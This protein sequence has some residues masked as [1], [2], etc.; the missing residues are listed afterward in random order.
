MQYSY[1]PHFLEG[2]SK[3]NNPLEQF[4][5]TIVF[6][7]T[8][9]HCCLIQEKPFNPILGETYQGVINGN[10]IYMEQTSHHPPAYSSLMKTDNYQVSSSQ[11]IRVVLNTNS[12]IC[13]NVGRTKVVYKNKNEVI[14]EKP[15]LVIRG[16]NVGNRRI[17]LEK[18]MYVYSPKH[19]LA[20][21]LSFGPKKGG[22]FSSGTLA[23]Q[24]SYFPDSD[25]LELFVEFGEKKRENRPVEKG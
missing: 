20:C 21:E 25:S 24:F 18:S 3:I 17:N 19:R 4:K 13:R 16:I 22:L 12:A 1:A 8:Q 11:E 15:L 23:D 5:Q 10:P 2:A 7:I 14:I 9:F 6:A